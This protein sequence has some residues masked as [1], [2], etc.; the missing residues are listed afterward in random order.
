MV[1]TD[2]ESIFKLAGIAHDFYFVAQC[3]VSWARWTL[4]LGWFGYFVRVHL[5]DSQTLWVI[6]SERAPEA[7]SAEDEVETCEVLLQ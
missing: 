6:L 2:L 5:Y 7:V 4:T 1:K 3:Y